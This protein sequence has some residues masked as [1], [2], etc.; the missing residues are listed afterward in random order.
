[1]EQWIQR[2]QELPST[3]V[4]DALQG[5]SQMDPGICPI[6][7]EYKVAGRAFTVSIPPGENTSVLRA[8]REAQPGDILVV[9]GKGF[10]SR[11][12][13]GDFIV[14]L[15][16]TLELGGLVIDGV[17]R[18]IG[19]TRELGFPVFCRGTTVAAS[20]KTGIG[21]LQVPICCGGTPVQPGDYIVGDRDGIVVIPGERIEEVLSKAEERMWKDEERS[22]RILGHPE[23]ARAYLD[24][25]L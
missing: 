5:K 6:K 10:L 12:V 4:S 1:M 21:E 18:D 24:S 2:L 17:I 11:A 9:D 8:I 23:A 15:A 7:D 25:V 14:G 3:C 22:A 16:Q 19:G 20:G 13:A